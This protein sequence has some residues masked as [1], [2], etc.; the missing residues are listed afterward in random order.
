M[1]APD[2]ESRGD[3]DTDTVES[4]PSPDP[5]LDGHDPTETVWVVS[6]RQCSGPKKYHTDRDCIKLAK[7][8][9]H[10]IVGRNAQDVVPWR[11]VCKTCAG[12]ENRDRSGTPEMPCPFCGAQESL[13]YHLPCEESPGDSRTG[14]PGSSEGTPIPTPHPEA[15]IETET[16]RQNE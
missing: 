3:T 15:E 1:A 11:D 2:P 9:E 14:A 10:N 8:T 6:N 7:A 12:T 5:D 13:P 16:R 4:D